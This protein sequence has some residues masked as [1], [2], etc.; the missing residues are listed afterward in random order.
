MATPLSAGQFLAALKTEG[1]KVVELSG[2]ATHNRNSKGPWGPMNGVMIHHTGSDTTDP[3]GYVR[4]VLWSGYSTLPGPLCHSGID[5]SGRVYLTGYG[6]ANHAGGG[7]P[8]S[9]NSVVN[10]SFS[11][12]LKPRVGNSNGV[13]G[14]SHFYGVEVM[15]SG[16]HAMAAAQRDAAIRWAAALCKAHGWS[17]KSVIGHREWSSDKWDPGAESMDQFRRDVQSRIDGGVA[18]KPVPPVIVVSPV[19]KPV[20]EPEVVVETIDNSQEEY[21]MAHLYKIANVSEAAG[22]K[23]YGQIVVRDDGQFVSLGNPT[24]SKAVAAFIAVMGGKLSNISTDEL[25]LVK[26]ILEQFDTPAPTA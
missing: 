2:W 8:N 15:Y 17:A 20:P 4:N 9:L 26:A 19:A 22:G 18:A 7:D 6:R 16:G 5:A 21:L 24:N 11:G 10:E 12:E 1:L 25:K 13:D 23:A 14:N 3:L